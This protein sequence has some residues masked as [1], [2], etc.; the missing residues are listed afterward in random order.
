MPL[1]W[2][3]WRRKLYEYFSIDM[4]FSS[5]TTGHLAL[6]PKA[7][8][9]KISQFVNHKSHYIPVVISGGHIRSNGIRS[10]IKEHYLYNNILFMHIL[11]M[12][13]TRHHARL[14]IIQSL[15]YSHFHLTR[16]NSFR[17]RPSVAWKHSLRSP[18]RWIVQCSTLFSKMQELNNL[19][20]NTNW[21][22]VFCLNTI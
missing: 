14:N 8:S 22:Y 4:G 10:R 13:P 6:N 17:T 15:R 12:I 19:V 9:L 21:I 2:C 18:F 7:P 1:S 20:R 5:D 3:I 11:M 16:A